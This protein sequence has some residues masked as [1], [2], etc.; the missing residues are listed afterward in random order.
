MKTFFYILPRTTVGEFLASRDE[1]NLTAQ[2]F[3]EYENNFGQL[4]KTYTTSE[5]REN[6]SFRD[7]GDYGSILIKTGSYL[8][9]PN[10]LTRR[11]VLVESTQEPVVTTDT[12]AFMSRQL[13]K[14]LR[15]P[16]YTKF[17]KTD[18][19][20][21][22]VSKNSGIS[23]YMWVRS[24]SIDEGSSEGSWI[25]V[26]SFVDNLTTSVEK[27]GGS[28]SMSLPPL[29]IGLSDDDRWS[30]DQIKSYSGGSNDNY[31]ST[32]SLSRVDG[33]EGEFERN[34]LFFNTV[35]QK[36]D[37]VYI[38]F[39]RLTIDGEVNEDISEISP[40]DIV[41]KT[42]D[43]IAL[44]DSVSQSTT[45]SNTSVSTNISGRDLMKILTDDSST[46]FPSAFATN[47]FV[48]SSDGVL[49]R[50]NL[51]ELF[52]RQLNIVTSKSVETNLKFI[53]NKYSNIGYV[54]DSVFNNYGERAVKEKYSFSNVD[55]PFGDID[56]FLG[57]DRRGV[58]R[59]VDFLF[60]PNASKRSTAD[61]GITQEEGAIVNTIRKFC[62]EPL[63]E[64]F[65]DTYGDKYYF[66]VRKPPF[67]K[68]SATGL[69]YDNID[70]ELSNS[71]LPIS[72]AESIEL[73]S[74]SDEGNR[75]PS[76][77]DLV[78]VVNEE[79]VLQENLVYDDRAYSWY[80]Y[81]PQGN[82]FGNSQTTTLAYIPLVALDEYAEVFGN[83][84]Y[85]ITSTY[86]P[87]TSLEQEGEELSQNSVESQAFLD[88]KYIIESTQ[89]LPFTRTGTITING[90][91][92]F[93]RGLYIHYKPTNEVF[94]VNKVLNSRYQNTQ[95]NDRTTTLSVSRGMREPY[96]RGVEIDIN[97]STQSVS[98]FNLV[99][100]D[101]GENISIN[102]N[103]FLKN[104]RVNSDIFNF[105]LQRRQWQ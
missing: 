76:L 28:F 64:F 73:G 18:N 58:W 23:V 10:S 103:D 54:P 51:S 55:G 99:N 86:T 53:L 1:I 11:N 74:V 19:L 15:D 83:N 4:S 41:G 80:Q 17:D 94:Y 90:D 67:D 98:Y 87:F 56:P 12:K 35:V 40:G 16:N 45:A 33:F 42:Y 96:I 65:G 88:L 20:G 9:I 57:Q 77:S 104:W 13:E 25:N 44:V 84:P 61:S 22:T 60:E 2:E 63:V 43:M 47:L 31:S 6:N 32:V 24:L 93:K 100:T 79:D 92:T 75:T 5:F 72:D 71:S 29:S 38:R 3:I 46:F 97:G 26:S 95:G 70:N 37:L 69:I 59:I 30:I 34:P 7:S 66:T 8:S 82:F 48:N 102:N 27:L 14:L 81:N 101:L 36:N 85:S 21:V 89:A 39:E 91:R 105:F 68:S 52:L 62:Q 78:L 49:A 50:R